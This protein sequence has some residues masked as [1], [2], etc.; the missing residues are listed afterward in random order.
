MGKP[1]DRRGHGG[2]RREPGG[3]R[4]FYRLLVGVPRCLPAPG[5][6]RFRPTIR[7]VFTVFGVLG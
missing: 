7:V 1:S 6:P 3:N 4:I 2:Q 5:R